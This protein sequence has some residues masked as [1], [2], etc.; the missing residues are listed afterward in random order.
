MVRTDRIRQARIHTGASKADLQEHTALAGGCGGSPPVSGAWIGGVSSH[1]AAAGHSPN[2]ALR[3]PAPPSFEMLIAS[4]TARLIS[5]N[6]I[7][8]K[9]RKRHFTIQYGHNRTRAS[10]LLHLYNNTLLVL[11]C[12]FYEWWTVIHHTLPLGKCGY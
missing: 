12:I 2:A 6:R 11:L 4:T 9:Q 1:A 3:G 7:K 10:L 8:S 5:S